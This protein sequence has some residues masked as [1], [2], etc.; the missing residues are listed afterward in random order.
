MIGF[1]KIKPTTFDVYS[2]ANLPGIPV[3]I[4]PVILKGKWPL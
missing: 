1:K 2:E 4:T 3:A